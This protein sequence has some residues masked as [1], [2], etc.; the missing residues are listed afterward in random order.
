MSEWKIEKTIL[1]IVVTVLFMAIFTLI[2]GIINT[3]I[4]FHFTSDFWGPFSTFAG[5]MLGAVITGGLA[6]YINNKESR[7]LVKK[8]R[9]TE[10]KNIKILKHYLQLMDFEFEVILNLKKE[11]E[12]I[13]NPWDEIDMV[14]VSHGDFHY[15][16][17]PPREELNEYKEKVDSNIAVTKRSAQNFIEEYSKMIE[18]NT[19]NLKIEQLDIYLKTISNLKLDVIPAIQYIKENGNNVLNIKEQ[20]RIKGIINNLLNY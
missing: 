1:Y 6:I 19:D 8:E 17:T 15:I 3:T 5:A 13:E 4:K 10:V 9:D 7:R 12:S 18:I 14:E 2:L 16:G 20:Q 11:L